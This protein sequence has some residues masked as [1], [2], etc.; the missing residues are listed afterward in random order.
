MKW[1]TGKKLKSMDILLGIHFFYKNI[2]ISNN[3]IYTK[4]INHFTSIYFFED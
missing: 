3:Y 1:E 4:K 2:N